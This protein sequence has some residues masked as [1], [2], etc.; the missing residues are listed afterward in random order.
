MLND[1]LNRPLL[2]FQKQSMHFGG[3]FLEPYERG[4]AG[5]ARSHRFG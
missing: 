1:G 5:L 3:L 2:R 4:Q